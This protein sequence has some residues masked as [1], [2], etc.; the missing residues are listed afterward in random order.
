[1]LFSNR[2]LKIKNLTFTPYCGVGVCVWGGGGG[3]QDVITIQTSTMTPQSA[4]VSH[5]DW[6][7]RVGQWLQMHFTWYMRA[8]NNNGNEHRH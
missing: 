2:N 5:V 7:W 8:L 1:M 4:T 6:C 3:Y